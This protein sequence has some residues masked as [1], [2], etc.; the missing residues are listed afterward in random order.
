MFIKIFLWLRGYLLIT[1]KGRSPERFINLCNNNN[2]YIWNLN[3]IDGYYRFEISV[4][5]YKKLKPIAKKTHTI[6]FIEKKVGLPFIL[7]PYKKRKAFLTGIIFFCALIYLFSLHIW[8][9]TIVGGQNYTEERLIKYLK[10]ENIYIGKKVK[11]IDCR[12]IEENIRENYTDIGWVSA[13]IKGT[14]LIIKIRE[15]VI[16]SP[17]ISRTNPTHIIAKKDGIISVMVTRTGTPLVEVGDVVKKRGH[18]SI[19]SSRYC[20]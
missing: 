16:P 3:N 6:P 14:N 18:T 4:K 20:W 13:E 17:A 15:T 9:I 12:R 2:I 19:R 11:E 8:N 7:Y 10:E 5:D 1:M